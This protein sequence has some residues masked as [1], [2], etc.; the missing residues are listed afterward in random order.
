MAD[1]DD[2]V[3]R[4]A[5]H[6]NG[7]RFGIKFTDS[8]N[9]SL[10]AYDP[11]DDAMGAWTSGE[12]KVGDLRTLLT[13]LADARREGERLEPDPIH[14]T[15][16]GRP[17]DPTDPMGDITPFGDGT[18]RL[19]FGCIPAAPD[20]LIPDDADEESVLARVWLYQYRADYNDPQEFAEALMGWRERLAARASSPEAR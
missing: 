12:L 13:A 18:A 6:I 11:E 2:V 16:C 15:A 7:E 5:A 4:V 19:C 10:L 8:A 3:A 14:C 17:P 9:V 1:L 20:L